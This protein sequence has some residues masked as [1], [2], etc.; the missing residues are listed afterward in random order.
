M[1]NRQQI[2]IL[3]QY[4]ETK[5]VKYYDVQCELVDHLADAMEELQNEKSNSSFKEL[6]FE[7]DSRFAP[8]DFS[9]IVK[10]KSKSI[11]K[12]YWFLFRKEFISFFRI[13]KVFLLM[14]VY[15]LL[16]FFRKYI[17]ND[18]II[19]GV[20]ITTLYGFI[21]LIY[22]KR[23]L[24]IEFGTN[25]FESRFPLVSL[26]SL[27]WVAEKIQIIIFLFILFLQ[28]TPKLFH[29]N[30]YWIIFYPILTVAYIAISN[31]SF[32]TRCQ[33]KEDYSNAFY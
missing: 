11:R 32:Q 23:I 24:N 5:G 8:D 6:L 22:W 31:I 16:F 4:C 13:P 10:S 3:Y 28:F 19:L 33:I 7:I 26:K 1:L 25:L 17:N 18:I 2:D 27:K 14:I 9:M 30:F 29:T 21:G 12:K 15:V 20:N